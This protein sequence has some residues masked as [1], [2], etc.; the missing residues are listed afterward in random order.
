MGVPHPIPYQ[1]SKRGL[2]RY[3]ISFFPKDA[4]RLIEPFAGSAAVSLAA[5]YYGKAKKFLLNDL[6]RALMALWDEII[7]KPD[8]LTSAYEQLWAAQGGRERDFYDF[9]RVQFNQIP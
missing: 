4:E 8:N 7:N 6:N 1:G 9:I 3:I 5:A 2:A